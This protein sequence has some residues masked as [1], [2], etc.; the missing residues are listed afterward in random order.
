VYVAEGQCVVSGVRG[1]RPIAPAVCWVADEKPTY[2][3][4]SA[5]DECIGDLASIENTKRLTDEQRV[6]ED[7][8][9]G[10]LLDKQVL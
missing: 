5:L 6:D 3:W 9:C 4:W 1:L 10:V 8:R 7:L 2:R